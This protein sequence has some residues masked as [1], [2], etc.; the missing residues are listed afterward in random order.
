[1]KIKKETPAYHAAVSVAVFSAYILILSALLFLKS[2]SIQTVNLVPFKSISDYLFNGGVFALGNVIGNIIMFIPMGV[3]LMLFNGDKGVALN[4]LWTIGVSA[5]A[6]A[7]QYFMK[8]GAAD[9]DDIILNAVGGLAGIAVYKLIYRIFGEKSGYA[10]E[11]ISIIC[12]VGF[13]TLMI[14][15]RFGVFGIKIRILHF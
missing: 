1:M 9:I 15:L 13:V 2:S 6:E 11:I 14:C 7:A 4:L 12:A 8:L 5:C 10:I 3:Y